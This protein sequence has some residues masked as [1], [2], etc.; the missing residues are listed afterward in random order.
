M[1]PSTL[2]AEEKWFQEFGSKCY[3]KQTIQMAG[4]VIT[5]TKFRIP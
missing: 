2:G 1:K 3:S 4:V 5:V